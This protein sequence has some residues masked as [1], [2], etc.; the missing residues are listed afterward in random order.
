[1]VWYIPLTIIPGVALLILSTTNLIVSLNAEIT[2]LRKEKSEEI[3]H[4][5]KLKLGQLTKL[6]VAI[7]FL[8]FAVLLLLF[9]GVVQGLSDI[10][11]TVGKYLLLGSI[12]F[13]TTAISIL[14]V[15]SIKAVKIRIT[16]LNIPSS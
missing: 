6:S 2:A 11:Q 7:S 9:S 14:I 16:H 13:V 5:V 1:M 4:I 10:Y 12:L 15:Y 3:K 8:Y